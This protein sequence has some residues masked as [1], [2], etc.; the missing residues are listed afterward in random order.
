MKVTISMETIFRIV[1]I[2]L[3]LWFLYGIRSVLAII[4]IAIIFSSA[5]NPWVDALHRWRIPRV[6]ALLIVFLV[7]LAVISVILILFIPALVNEV[8]DLAQSLPSLYDRMVSNPT[9]ERL[10]GDTNILTS[11]RQSL[12]TIDQS[13]GKITGPIFSALAAAFGGLFTF[14]GVVVLTF[15]FSLE[16]NGI[17]KF[18][19]AIFPARTQPYITRLINRVQDRMGQWLRGQLLLSGII[20][21]LSFIALTILGVKYALLLALIAGLTEAIP[22]I[23]PISG[24]IPAVLFALTQNP[25][26]AVAVAIA[27][28]VIQQLENNLI[29][30]RVMARATGLNPIV[31]I[32]VMLIGAKVAGIVGLLLAI[33][34]TIIINAFLQDFIE[35][36][37]EK[38]T[39]LA[40]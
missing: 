16:E 3:V 39:A 10:I 2:G 19:Q 24:A 11:V 34:V 40:G 35:E 7:F 36:R 32:I 17:R 6:L 30:P 20:G 33:P 9:V 25:W 18:L 8:R 1:L 5:I 26:T 22:M 4:L 37:E 23:G 14:I 12:Q 31:V 13:L 15:Y 38:D 29:V 28:L 27:Y 21:L